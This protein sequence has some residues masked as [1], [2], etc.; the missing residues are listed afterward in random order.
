[1]CGAL[2]LFFLGWCSCG[3]N[4]IILLW[5]TLENKLEKLTRG[6]CHRGMQ[7]LHDMQK[8]SNIHSSLNCQYLYYN[9]M[10]LQG[11]QCWWTALQY[12]PHVLSFNLFNTSS[13]FIWHHEYASCSGPLK[14]FTRWPKELH[15]KNVFIYFWLRWVFSA[16]RGLSLATC[17]GFSHCV[18][19]APEQRLSSHSTQV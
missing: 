5:G 6:K 10:N 12:F 3:K 15:L 11:N 18:A 19:R 8:L 13:L 4:H 16:A 1:M 2:I 14:W 7:S 17:T 9:G